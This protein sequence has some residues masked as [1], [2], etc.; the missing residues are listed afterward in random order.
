MDVTKMLQE[1]KAQGI[2]A[3]MLDDVL[4]IK[5][6]NTRDGKTNTADAIAAALQA[7]YIA[8][9]QTATRDAQEV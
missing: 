4:Q 7:G 3:F 2:D 5:A 6:L 9:Y 1:Y 8:G